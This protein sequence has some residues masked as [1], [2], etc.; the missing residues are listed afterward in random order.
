MSGGL[1][2][3]S[4]VETDAAAAAVGMAPAA[5]REWAARRGLRAVRHVRLGRST[6]AVWDLRQVYE[7]DRDYPRH[8]ACDQEVA[9][10][11]DLDL[12]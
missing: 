6:I 2:V 1:P 5:F 7:T 11:C 8:A 10:R 12:Q 9:L 4:L 3:S